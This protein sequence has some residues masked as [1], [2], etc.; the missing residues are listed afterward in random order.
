M[1]GLERT[2]RS[3]DEVLSLPPNKYGARTPNTTKPDSIS[4]RKALQH[5]RLHSH[6]HAFLKRNGIIPELYSLTY[7]LFIV[8]VSFLDYTHH[9]YTIQFELPF[10]FI[11]VF[12]YI[13]LSTI[14]LLF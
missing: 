9:R 8:V 2:G 10:S 4:C 7:K 6:C 3:I 14:F 11:E 13:A 12:W 5:L 1:R